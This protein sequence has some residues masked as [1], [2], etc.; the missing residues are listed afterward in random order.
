MRPIVALTLLILFPGILSAFLVLGGQLLQASDVS[1]PISCGA[2]LGI[3]LH[4]Y[5]L[6]KIAGY[7]TFVHEMTHA[8]AALM[9]FRRVTDFVATRHQ[10]GYVYYGNGWGGELGNE[11]IGLAPY[12][13]PIFTLFST[14]ARPLVP[15]YWFPWFDFFIG[16]TFGFHLLSTAHQIRLN[17]TSRRFVRA[18]A[19]TYIQSDFAQRGCLYSAIGIACVTTAVHGLLIAVILYG[20]PGIARW[21]REVGA[22]AKGTILWT[23]GHIPLP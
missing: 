23:L 1:L 15:Q 16:V 17:W 20:F 5:V 11:F 21:G 10:G 12:T 22:T 14:L 3:L 6:S 18:G 4:R 9:L 8:I 13:L 2:L 19:E 7:E